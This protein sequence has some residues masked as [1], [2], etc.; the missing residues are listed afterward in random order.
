M[1]ALKTPDAVIF[2]WDNTLVDTWPIIY[3]ALV[4]TF[5][6]FDIEPWTLDM[7]KTNVKK[8]MRDSFPIVF[9]DEWERAADIYQQSYRS[10]VL[11][12]LT[13]LEGSED[14][15]KLLK[16]QGTPMFVVSNKKGDNLRAELE[17]LDWNHYFLNAVGAGDAEEDKP[18]PAPVWHAI[19]PHGFEGVEGIWFV[20]DSDVDLECAHNIGCVPILYGEH[21]TTLEGY[22][23]ESLNGFAYTH[24]A[25][26][27]DEFQELVRI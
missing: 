14:T 3:A 23:N 2:D 21:A 19:K 8:S 7:V 15:L 26:G 5:K 6:A 16:Q 13:A 20:G 25:L 22:T 27:H 18:S 4:Q 17:H 9:G 11:A 1:V 24:H 12:N 10:S